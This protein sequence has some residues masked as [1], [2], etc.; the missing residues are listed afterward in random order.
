MTRNPRI[1]QKL[2]NKKGMTIS[3]LLVATIIILLVS[4]GMVTAIRQATENFAK[5]KAQS[6][7]KVLCSSLETEVEN[8]LRYTTWIE[9]KDGVYRYQSKT[10]ANDDSL[11]TLAL[12]ESTAKEFTINGISRKYGKVV[13]FY[14][15]VTTGDNEIKLLPDGMYPLNLRAYMEITDYTQYRFTVEISI[16]DKDG[17]ELIQDNFTVE[18][19]NHTSLS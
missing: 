19:L 5:E 15:D 6:E 1:G 2:H 10:H 7:A 3:E 18:N 12:E 13:L 14:P 4:A 17:K 8:E 9:K 11:T 16:V